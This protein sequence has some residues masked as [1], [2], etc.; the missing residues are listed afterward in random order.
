MKKLLLIT[1]SLTSLLQAH[2]LKPL[3]H[4][5]VIEFRLL[6]S[7]LIKAA[8]GS[9]LCDAMG[10]FELCRNELNGTRT[11]SIFCLDVNIFLKIFKRDWGY[12]FRDR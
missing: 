1:V 9:S 12:Y 6:N 2:N 10:I 4:E 3:A 8:K 11:D 5:E 7:P